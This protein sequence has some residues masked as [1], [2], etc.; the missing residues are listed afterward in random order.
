[1]KISKDKKYKTK[2]GKEVKIYEIY[3][4]EIHGAYFNSKEWECHSWSIIGSFIDNEESCLDLIE[5]SP[6]YRI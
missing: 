1:M 2:T 6:I 4:N 5:I 3:D